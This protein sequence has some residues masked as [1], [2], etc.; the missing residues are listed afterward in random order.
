MRINPQLLFAAPLPSTIKVLSALDIGD[1]ALIELFETE[2]HFK[3]S[4]LVAA[5]EEEKAKIFIGNTPLIDSL[6]NF[7][8][9]K[10]LPDG[11]PT[12]LLRYA[13]AQIEPLSA[14]KITAVKIGD[15]DWQRD[16]QS[17]E[18]TKSANYLTYFD[19]SPEARWLVLALKKGEPVNSKQIEP[20]LRLIQPQQGLLPARTTGTV[21]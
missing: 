1:A 20:I 12:A 5:Q 8:E 15:Q 7:R 3:I 2:A 21:E 6:L 9:K 10:K 18:T 11:V 4:I 17:F 13:L 14:T 16:G 19:S